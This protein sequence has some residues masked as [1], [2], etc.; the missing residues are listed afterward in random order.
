MKEV[1]CVVSTEHKMNESEFKQKEVICMSCERRY[2]TYSVV[3]NYL[4]HV[5]NTVGVPLLKNAVLYIVCLFMK[6]HVY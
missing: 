2:I 3:I 6:F 1:K 4:S 5:K